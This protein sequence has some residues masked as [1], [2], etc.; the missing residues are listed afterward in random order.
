M[1]STL[2][3]KGYIIEKNSISSDIIQD[4]K[5]EL[6]VTPLVMNNYGKSPEKFAVYSENDAKNIFASRSVPRRKL[7]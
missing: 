1:K 6:I 7:A 3:R 5:N 2:S 4:I